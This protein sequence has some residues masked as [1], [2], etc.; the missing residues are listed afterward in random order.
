M[1]ACGQNRVAFGLSICADMCVGKIA[2]LTIGEAVTHHT[3]IRSEIKS[4][5]SKSGRKSRPQGRPLDSPLFF[6]SRQKD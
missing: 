4:D 1:L 3:E 2:S 6:C 5:E